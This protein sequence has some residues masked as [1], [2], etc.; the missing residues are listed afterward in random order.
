[1]S[2]Y[3]VWVITKS[4]NVRKALA[5]FSKNRKVAPY[6]KVRKED[7][8]PNFRKNNQRY[9]ESWTEDLKAARSRND[10]VGIEQTEETIALIRKNLCLSDEKIYREVT[11][12]HDLDENG[13]ILST[14][15]PN[16]K[17]DYYD[18]EGGCWKNEIRT[19]DGR[20]V[21]QCRVRDLCL[22]PGP[23]DQAAYEKQ[24]HLFLVLTRQKDPESDAEKEALKACHWK[25]AY[26]FDQYGDADTFAQR[27]IA[28]QPYAV[29]LADGTWVEPDENEDYIHGFAD[30]M[31]RQ[32]QDYM[33]TCVD[34]HI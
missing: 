4:G 23:N 30:L 9:L 34:C 21:N 26:Y 8:V 15:N 3:E 28:V 22:M 25:P 19:K 7:I 13:N 12:G 27:Q 20:N 24:K 18:K 33:V 5:P 31:K 6:I 29:L 10:T 14:N 32:P 1:M 16:S 11:D 17:W 2:H